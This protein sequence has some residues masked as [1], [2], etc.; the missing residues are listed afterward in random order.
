MAVAA[1]AVPGKG[2]GCDLSACRQSLRVGRPE[3]RGISE[4]EQ[5]AELHE[6]AVALPR[7][8]AEGQRV[9]LGQRAAVSGE[10]DGTRR[11]L[12][13]EQEIDPQAVARLAQRRLVGAGLVAD[14]YR[15]LGPRVVAQRVA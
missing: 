15:P 14:E 5:V 12:P 13:R 2:R 7:E 3:A 10:E 4:P 9:R 11:R 1:S 8:A 6:E